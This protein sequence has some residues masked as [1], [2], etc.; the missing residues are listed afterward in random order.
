MRTD[1]GLRRRGGFSSAKLLV[2]ALLGFGAYTGFQLLPVACAGGNLERAVANALQTV[3]HTSTD[4]AIRRQIAKHAG[5][6][7]LEVDPAWVRVE[8]ESHPGRRIVHV[9]VDMPVPVSWLGERT[10][11]REVRATRAIAVDEEAL[12]REAARRRE[13][14]AEQKRLRARAA[15][16]EER[17]QEA[18]AE[19]EEIHGEGNCVRMELPGFGSDEVQKLY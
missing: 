6:S 5:V 9:S 11:H 18:L 1:R 16:R 8:R 15:E 13:Y 3:D 12:A 10:F 19:C 7:S 17:V 2:W 14:E 4:N